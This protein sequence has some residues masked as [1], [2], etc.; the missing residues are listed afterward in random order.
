MLV[1]AAGTRYNVGVLEFRILG[2]FEVLA[3][4]GEPLQLGGQRQR[5]V[6]AS[7]L[8][9]ANEVVSTDVLVDRLWG[10]HPPRTARTSLQNAISTLRPRHPGVVLPTARPSRRAWPT[11]IGRTEPS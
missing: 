1:I 2:P 7:L 3:A 11:S 5:A 9:R 6:L 10:E 4:N 8:L